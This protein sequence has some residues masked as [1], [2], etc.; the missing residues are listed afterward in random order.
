[1][2]VPLVAVGSAAGEALTMVAA[3]DRAVMLIV[4]VVLPPPSAVQ[5]MVTVP[6][7]TVPGATVLKADWR[8]EM[9]SE[10]PKL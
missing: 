5:L 4:I 10:G 1:M 3:G 2:K 8:N 6:D 7:S 9:L